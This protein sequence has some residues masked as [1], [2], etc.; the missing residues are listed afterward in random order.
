MTVPL[1]NSSKTERNTLIID[2]DIFFWPE[3]NLPSNLQ[4][5]FFNASFETGGNS[6]PIKFD[7]ILREVFVKRRQ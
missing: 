2:R 3:K 4:N 6:F 7:F 5:K 1:N